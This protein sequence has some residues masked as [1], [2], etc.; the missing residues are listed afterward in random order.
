MYSLIIGVP[1]ATM[2]L[3]HHQQPMQ[4]THQ[5][6]H[7]HTHTHFGCVSWSSRAHCCASN[8]TGG[9]RVNPQGCAAGVYIYLKQSWILMV[10]RRG[11]L[12]Y[13]PASLSLP[14]SHTHSLSLFISL[15]LSFLWQNPG[16]IINTWHENVKTGPRWRQQAENG[17]LK[18]KE[19][20]SRGK[21]KQRERSERRRGR[22]QCVR[23]E[24]CIS[25]AVISAV[26]S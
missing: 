9:R 15:F 5:H 16:R 11:R 7:M 12:F 21:E 4:H 13:Q 1:L 8:P 17:V 19:N 23:K 10:T 14:L 2:T 24:L 6:A 26:L 20:D 18:E 25:Q 22:D 3:L